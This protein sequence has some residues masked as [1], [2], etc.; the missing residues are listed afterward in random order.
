MKTK[1]RTIWVPING[2]WLS[3][4]KDFR[5]INGHKASLR[6]IALAVDV[7]EQTYYRYIRTGEMPLDIVI[8]T[9]DV[10]NVNPIVF[11]SVEA[12]SSGDILVPREIFA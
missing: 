5:Y 10:L 7:T 8:A 11:S 6:R 9:A 12:T 1:L 3:C 4:Q 2:D